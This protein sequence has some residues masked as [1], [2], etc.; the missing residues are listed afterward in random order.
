[1]SGTHAHRSQRSAKS[2][3]RSLHPF[4]DLKSVQS[5]LKHFLDS[6]VEEEE[7]HEVLLLLLF[8]AVAVAVAVVEVA[9]REEEEEE[10]I[11]KK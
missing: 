1:L 7:Q 5:E 10:D 4:R 2:P 6:T 8:V 3:D 11:G 9:A